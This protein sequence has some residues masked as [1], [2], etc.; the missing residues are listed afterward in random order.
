MD[1]YTSLGSADQFV[2][3]FGGHVEY[4]HLA[5]LRSRDAGLMQ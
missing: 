5:L 3:L 1:Q 2:D 4:L